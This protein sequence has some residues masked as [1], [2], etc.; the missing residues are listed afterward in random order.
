MNNRIFLTLAIFTVT[1]LTS[2]EAIGDIFQAGMY[3]GVFIVIALVAVL[4]WVLRFFR[5]RS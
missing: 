2:C 4:V 3:V 5:R 1:L